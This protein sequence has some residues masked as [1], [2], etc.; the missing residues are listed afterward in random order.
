MMIDVKLF[1]I[2]LNCVQNI[3]KKRSNFQV[4]VLAFIINCIDLLAWITDGKGDFTSG[5]FFLMCGPLAG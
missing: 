4:L 5:V 2:V 3:K 1:V